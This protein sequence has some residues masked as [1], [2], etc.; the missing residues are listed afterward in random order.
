VPDV[1]TLL[2]NTPLVLDVGMQ[3]DSD[4]PAGHSRTKWR[5][6]FLTTVLPRLAAFRPDLILISAGFDA[7]KK[8]SINCGC[9][10]R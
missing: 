8:D 2:G 10:R 4:A 6:A 5:T 3:L 7:H 9:V 1:T